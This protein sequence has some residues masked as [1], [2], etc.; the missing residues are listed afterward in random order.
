MSSSLRLNVF[1][2]ADLLTKAFDG[3]RYEVPTSRTFIV[4]AG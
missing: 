1:T 3:P 4:P 2:E